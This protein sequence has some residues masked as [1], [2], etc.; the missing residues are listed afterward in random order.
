MPCALLL[1][2]SAVTRFSVFWSE[3][4]RVLIVEDNSVLSSLIAKRLEQAGIGSDQAVSVSQ[5]QVALARLGYVAVILDLGLPDGDGTEFIH[6]FRHWSNAPVLV[7]SARSAE[8]QKIAALD[9]GEPVDLIAVLFRG[10]LWPMEHPVKMVLT[11]GWIA[12][13]PHT[14]EGIANA[15]V[16]P[17]PP[18]PARR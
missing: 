6:D 3:P 13:Y 7:L 1:G 12:G 18:S 5:A 4:V 16:D 9:A 11:A 17:A 10:V 8:Q 15:E 2:F 14:G